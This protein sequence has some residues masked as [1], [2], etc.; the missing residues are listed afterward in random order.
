MHIKQ[1]LK[2]PIDFIYNRELRYSEYNSSNIIY[3][4]L[5]KITRTMLKHTNL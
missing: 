5:K 1:F 2:Y 4:N 3:L